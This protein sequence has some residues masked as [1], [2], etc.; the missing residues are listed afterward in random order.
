[1]TKRARE[2]IGL[3]LLICIGVRV[4]AWLIAPLLP[5][6][7]VLAVIIGLFGYIVGGP[8]YRGRH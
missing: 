7:I 2:A 6:L 8:R 4:A 3:V 5:A 1:V